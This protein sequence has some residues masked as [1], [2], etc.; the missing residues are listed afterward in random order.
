MVLRHHKNVLWYYIHHHSYSTHHHTGV[1]RYYIIIRVYHITTLHKVL[2]YSTLHHL[3]GVYIVKGV[4]DTRP[5]TC[6]PP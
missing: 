5:P 4:Y 6:D 1:L 3:R 2:L